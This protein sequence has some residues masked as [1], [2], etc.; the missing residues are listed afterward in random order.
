M[1]SSRLSAKGQTPPL[2]ANPAPSVRTSPV[3]FPQDAGPHDASTIEW[4]YI[5]A[6]LTTEAGKRY[7]LVGSFFRTGL[8]PTQKGH[9][10]IYALADLDAKK[11]AAYS[12]LDKANFDLLKAFLPL[13]AMQRP[14]DPRPM[15]LLGA[16]QKGGLPKPHRLYPETA[17]MRTKPM[18]AI[19]SGKNW[20]AQASEDGRTWKASLTGDDFSV[21]LRLSQQ[22][23]R[24]AMLVGGEGKTGLNRPDDMFYVSLTRM[25]AAGTLTVGGRTEK[26]TG[27][28]WLDRQWGTSWVVGDNGWDWFGLQLDDGTDVIVYRIKDNA[29]GK[30]L[31]TEATLLGK[32]GRLTVDKNPMFA[33]SGAWTDPETKITYPETFTVTIPAVGMTLTATPAFSEQVIPV[34]GIG[35]AIWEGV[36]NVTGTRA[37][38]SAVTGRGYRELVGYKAPAPGSGTA[39]P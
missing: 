32:D 8:T 1:A 36:V 20:L 39:S 22:A 11:K 4:W 17:K 28:G 30:V 34:I 38:G 18:F 2:P 37:D 23:Q 27:V 13:M 29:T 33:T 25:D 6:F 26:V 14:D 15:Q 10:L 35:D 16:L 12:V 7:A 24:P 31:R 3:G 19:S 5:N 21:S 9:Y